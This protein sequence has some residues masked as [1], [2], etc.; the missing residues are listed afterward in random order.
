MTHIHL[1]EIEFEFGGERQTI[2]P[3]IIRNESDTILVDSGYP[4]FLERLE[5][6]A[7]RQGIGF[8]TITKMILTHDDIDH[9]G[10]AAALKKKYPHVEILAFESEADYINGTRKSLRLEQAEQTLDELSG[11]ARTNAEQ[12]IRFLKSAEPVQVDR[13]LQQDEQLSDGDT[14]VIHTPGHTPGHISLYITSSKTL[15]AGDAL[16][17]ENEKLNIANPQYCLNLHD[18]IQSV[19]RLQNYEISRLICY[20]GGLFQGNVKKALSEVI[21]KYS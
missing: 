19:R 13:T 21:E 5:E 6:A 11:E 20:H 18:A 14:V 1:L 17:V 7:N 2:W 12:F 3:V 9:L 8:E 16:V 15:I 4:H 10:S